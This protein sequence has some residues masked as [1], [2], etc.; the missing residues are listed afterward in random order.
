PRRGCVSPTPASRSLDEVAE[1]ALPRPDSDPAVPRAAR[2]GGSSAAP[3]SPLGTDAVPDSLRPLY[4]L[5]ADAM[6]AGRATSAAALTA[7]HLSGQGLF[8]DGTLLTAPDGTPRGRHWTDQAGQEADTATFHVVSF[9]NFTSTPYPGPWAANGTPD[10]YLV[11]TAGGDHTA[12]ELALPD[13][14][15][16]RT[17]QEVF[18]E[19]LALDPVLTRTDPAAAVVLVSPKAADMGLELPRRA[20]FRARRPVWAHTGTVVLGKDPQ[21]PRRRINVL[22]DRDAKLPLGTWV[23]S[24]PDDWAD[25]ERPE[26]PAELLLTDGTTVHADEIKSVTMPLDGRPAGRALMGDADQWLREESVADLVSSSEWYAIDPV[27]ERPVG[28]PRPVPWRGR[29]PWYVWV[30]GEPGTSQLTGTDSGPRKTRG[31]ETGRYLRRTRSLRRLAPDVPIVL[32]ACWGD[33][34]ASGERVGFDIPTPF[35]AD[36]LAAPSVAQEIADETR[37]TVF[38]P[39]RTHVFW[40]DGRVARQG[41][42][43]S[44][45]GS[46]ADWTEVRPEPDQDGLD[47]LAETAGLGDLR[48]D[49][50]ERWDTALRLVRAL[51]QTFGVQVEDDHHAYRTALSGLGALEIMR[52]RDPDHAGDG[53]FTLELLER[54]TWA[55]TGQRPVA[56]TPRPT[57]LEPAEVRAT[58]RAARAALDADGRAVLSEFVSLPATARAR[59]LLATGDLEARARQVLDIPPGRTVT[60][61][62][63]RRLLW[64]TV[65]AV[66]AVDNHPDADALTRQVLH[67]PTGADPRDPAHQEALLWTAAGAAAVGRDVHSATALAAY[68]LQ[69]HG[70]LDDSTRVF[71]TSGRAVGRNWSTHPHTGRIDTDRYAVVDP[72]GGST[73]PDYPTPW[74]AGADRG[75]PYVMV[76]TPGT[77]PDTVA[78]PWP[79]GTSR[80]VPYQEIAELIR[81]DPDLRTT[82]PSE[83]RIVPVGL[84]P[85]TRRLGKVL[86]SRDAVGRTVVAT[87][88]RTDLREDP[89]T[90]VTDLVMTTTEYS[91]NG[92]WSVIRPR[93]LKRPAA[94][95]VVTSG[96]T[97]TASRASAP[98]PSPAAA[99]RQAPQPSTPDPDATELTLRQPGG[100]GDWLPGALAGALRTGAP[101]RLHGPG[102]G[103]LLSGPDPADALHR[104]VESRL[105]E[106]DAKQRAP[107]LGA[108]DWAGGRP[109]LTMD[110]LGAL[111][112]A[113]TGDPLAYATLSGGLPP[114]EVSL[115]LAQRY[116]LL[117]T[118]GDAGATVTEIAATLAAAELGIR[119]TI[120]GPGGVVRHFDPAPAGEPSAA[121]P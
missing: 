95:P 92:D 80:S 111:G 51:R 101:G 22:D 43:T 31:R 24:E 13:G 5:V 27:T 7:F 89:S 69:R 9:K 94:A 48:I 8:A 65:R 93:P 113:L 38:S 119:I 96:G 16:W 90:G 23:V 25:T 58:L 26:V 35:V 33:A 1:Q 12:V 88:R 68:D 97:S 100:D 102:L 120:V 98:L 52:R 76:L 49:A 55:H 11:A 45:L 2:P 37:R 53:A 47:A 62:D 75:T 104:W 121:L 78:I 105:A 84:G 36:R 19:L 112:V 61:A 32:M 39:N 6:A 29:K 18:A 116:R 70:A 110:E 30:H 86:A 103:A 46:L 63:R 44:A 67:L 107:R 34:L 41:V 85:D 74:A 28:A 54:V 109:M 114:G 56:G 17:S 4:D 40:N 21:R 72:T 79:D 50:Q 60:A 15:R 115:S 82:P 20:A 99:A 83:A 81:H 118:W 91:R 59:E 14:R 64:A 3:G 87:R 71:A 57:P 108:G 42:Y 10:P 117:R 77:E 106:P 73:Q 66:E